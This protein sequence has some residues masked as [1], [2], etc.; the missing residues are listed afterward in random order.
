MEKIIPDFKAVK[1]PAD[2]GSAGNT[3]NTGGTGQVCNLQ[4]ATVGGLGNGGH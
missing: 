2:V 3:G 4:G 1:P